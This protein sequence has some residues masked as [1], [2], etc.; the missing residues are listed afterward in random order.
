V[1]TANHSGRVT[2]P[3]GGQLGSTAVRCVSLCGAAAAWQILVSH[4]T[5]ARLEGEP[6]DVKLQDLGEKTL[7]GFDRPARVFEID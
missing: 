1:Q 2:D 7:K 6:T 3:R 5:E 4:S